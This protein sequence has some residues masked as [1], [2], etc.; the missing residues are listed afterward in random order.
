[1]GGYF[2]TALMVDLTERTAEESLLPGEW[3]RDYI[4]GEGL[5]VRLLLDLVDPEADLLSP[6]QPLIFSTGS[7]TGTAAPAS[8]RCAVVFRSPLTGTLGA[9]NAGGHFAPALKRAGYDVLVVTGQSAEPVVL[10]IDDE[11]VDFIEAREAWG[12]GVG[13]TEDWVRDQVEGTGWQIASIGP[14]GERGVLFANIVTD[15]HRAFGRGGAGA[16]MG[17]K[18]L[19]AIA[20]RGTGE[21]PLSDP[22]GLKEAAKAAREELFNEAF[23]RDE[24][25]PYGTPSFYDAMSGLGILPTRNWQ[26]DSFPESIPTLGYAAYHETLEVRPYACFGCPI[27]CGRH[28]KIRTGKWAG[29]EGGGPEY[30]TVAAFGSKC[31]VMDLNAVAAANHLANDLGLDVI[32]TGQVIATAMEWAEKGILGK[33]RLGDLALAFGNAEAVVE[34]VRLIANREGIGDLLAEG[35]ARAAEKLGPEA[36]A[37]VMA[38]R[39]MEMAADGVRGSKGE[40][41]S[42]AVSPRGA[43]HLRPYASTVDAFG[44]REPELGIAA[45]AAI[46]IIEDGNKGWV[47]PLMA[48][49]MIPNLIGTCLFTNITL[50]I[51]PSTWAGLHSKAVGRPMGKDEL[52]LAAERVINLERMVNATFGFDGST[53]ILPERFLKEPGADGPGAGQVVNLKESLESFYEAMGWEPEEGLPSVET[54][55]RLGLDWI[56]YGCD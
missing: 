19:K 30:E 52:L 2:G 18:N 45:D 1:M 51:K 41:V 12:K 53:D 23:V 10:V 49:A 35:S 26:R 25:K 9:S 16:L 3:Y 31:E 50:A 56:L 32:S 43:D 34:A 21:L 24:M 4:G 6:Q 47:K 36:E 7:L 40:A 27:A 5:G 22:E 29:M 37:A 8:G 17:S 28:T 46:S 15:R 42:H 55:T 11:G 14:A 48:N 54:L 33:D 13:A 44:Y 39:G 20:V 38:V